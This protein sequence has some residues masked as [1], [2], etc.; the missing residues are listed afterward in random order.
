MTEQAQLSLLID[1]GASEDQFTD[2][3][4]ELARN[5][6]RAE[7]VRRP[8]D[9]PYASLDW[10]IPTGII[11]LVAKPYYETML[12]KMAEDHYLLLKKAAAKLWHKFFGKKP[13]IE[14]YVF[15]FDGRVKE[16]IFSRGFSIK[17]A[18]LEGTK[19]TMLFLNDTPAEDFELGIEEFMKLMANHY[20]S[21]GTDP[22]SE[23]LNAPTRRPPKT[24]EQLVYFD[25]ASKEIDL[26]DYVTSAK[27][28]KL[29]SEKIRK[30][31]E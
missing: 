17:S 16:S 14:R 24:W 4:G 27:S 21:G 8:Q 7:I 9:G 2:F 20:E 13:E 15:L 12:K 10:L 3:V 28:G 11:L 19:I 1:K 18:T 5:G 6:L 29:V 31:S 26:I 25:S 30:Q 22:L 23:M